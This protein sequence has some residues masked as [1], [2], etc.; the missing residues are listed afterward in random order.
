MIIGITGSFGSGKTTVA[1]VFEKLGADVIDAD[2]IGHRVIEEDEIKS[3]LIKEFGE[4][5]VEGRRINRKTLANIV[6]SDKTKVLRLNQIT[7]P[8]ILKEI[9]SE[10]KSR[11]K[12]LIVVVAP[13]LIEAGMLKMVDVAILITTERKKIT[14]RLKEKG[15]DEE[16]IKRRM[17]FHPEDRERIERVQFIIDN[18]GRLTEIGAQV[19][20]VLDEIQNI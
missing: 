18:N 1:R 14:E 8:K 11:Q 6:F 12:E 2:S 17:K 9:G 4:E 15:W 16:D 20:R 13:F 10:I 5:I 3:A 19:K 7:H